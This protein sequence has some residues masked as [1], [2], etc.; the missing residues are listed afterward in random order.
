M[1]KKTVAIL[2]IA[3]LSLTCV[4]AG[5]SLSL[6]ISPYA[7]QTISFQTSKEYSSENG[8]GMKTGYRYSYS[9]E[10][11]VGAD[12]LF[13]D[14]TYE[15]SDNSYIVFS[16]MA[17]YGFQIPINDFYLDF[18]MGAGIDLRSHNSITKA[19]PSFGTYLGAGY[20]ADDRFSFTVGMDFHAAWQSHSTEE[21]SSTD[22]AVLFN[23]GGRIDL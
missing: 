3:L 10:A 6:Q 9:K 20:K 11:F 1:R 2:A 19:Y 21:L 12:I 5:H 16:T 7:T 23:F 13:E 8:I 22:T 4:F 17:K 18:D 14:Y 15:N